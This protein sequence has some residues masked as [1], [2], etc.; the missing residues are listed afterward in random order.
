MPSETVR[1]GSGSP[2]WPPRRRTPA[3]TSGRLIQRTATSGR[4]VT[5]REPTG[6]SYSGHGLQPTTDAVVRRASRRTLSDG[7]A[8]K[9]ARRIGWVA[10]YHLHGFSCGY[11]FCLY[12][13]KLRSVTITKP[14]PVFYDRLPDLDQLRPCDTCRPTPWKALRLRAKHGEGLS[15]GEEYRTGCSAR[16]RGRRSGPGWRH[17]SR[18]RRGTSTACRPRR[19]ERG[20]SPAVVVADYVC[21]DYAT[22]MGMHR[23]IG[24]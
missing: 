17:A 20:S 18:P 16:A 21:G 8:L 19:C 22:K 12:A 5:A 13:S 11:S 24:G 2:A 7:G 15:R 4:R 9:H 23:R 1:A 6:G 10:G 3:A 14:L